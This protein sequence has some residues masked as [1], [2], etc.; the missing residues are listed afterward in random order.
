MLDFLAPYAKVAV[1]LQPTDKSKRGDSSVVRILFTAVSGNK[2]TGPIPTTISSKRT[3]PEV[4][5]LKRGGCYAQT[6]P[7][8]MHWTRLTNGAAGLSWQDF[9]KEIKRLWPGQLW[10]HNTAGDLQGE[11]DKLDRKA[12]RELTAANRDKRV[13]CYSHYSPLTENVGKQ[14]AEHN[15]RAIK[16]AVSNGFVINLSA[17]SMVH[18]D[19]LVAL[20][21]APVVTVLPSTQRTNC[22]TPAGNRVV[23]CPATREGGAHGRVTCA[24]CGLC[25]RANRDYIIGFPAHGTLYGKVNTI[26]AQS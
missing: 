14:T 12:L 3:C 6:G 21:I 4:C 16:E 26:A 20:G 7:L 9:L 25:A 10:R 22:L 19:K 2:K 18:A 15:K 5:P 8:N 17:N 1:M 11:N 24:R 13:I 23:V